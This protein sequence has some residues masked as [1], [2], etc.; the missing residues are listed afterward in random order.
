MKIRNPEA[1]LLISAVM[2]LDIV[3]L[4]SPIVGILDVASRTGSTDRTTHHVTAKVDLLVER[5]A[6]GLIHR[7]V[8]VG[9]VVYDGLLVEDMA[10][11]AQLAAEQHVIDVAR[12][13]LLWRLGARQDRS[14]VVRSVAAAAAAARRVA[15]LRGLLVLDREVL[16]QI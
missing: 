13:A 5:V 16:S 3:Y 6:V 8:H 15:I 1:N 2:E 9:H 4:E 7:V 14:L 11:L 10:L 12:L